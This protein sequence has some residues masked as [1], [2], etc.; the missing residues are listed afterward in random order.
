MPRTT[1][2]LDSNSIGIYALEEVIKISI[3]QMKLTGQSDEVIEV[4]DWE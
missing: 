3:K 1:S 4:Y 2:C